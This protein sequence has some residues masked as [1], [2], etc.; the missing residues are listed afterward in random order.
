MVRVRIGVQG[1]RLLLPFPTVRWW[2]LEGES[3]YLLIL[4]FS[5]HWWE[6][7]GESYCFRWWVLSVPGVWVV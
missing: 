3:Y 1:S 4:S 6:F 2:E 5:V 7:E